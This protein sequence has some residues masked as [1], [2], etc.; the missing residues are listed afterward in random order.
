MNE[1]KEYS[2][3][4]EEVKN[5]RDEGTL[6]FFSK[7]FHPQQDFINAL[8][9]FWRKTNFWSEKEAEVKQDYLC[10]SPAWFGGPPSVVKGMKGRRGSFPATYY[11]FSPLVDKSKKGTDNVG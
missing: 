4:I 1:Q 5:L 10:R 8:H 11:F 6:G 2:L 7:G 3:I 9:R